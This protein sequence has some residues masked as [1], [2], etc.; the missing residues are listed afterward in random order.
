MNTYLNEALIMKE[1]LLALLLLVGMTACPA[2]VRSAQS[3]NLPS[4]NLKMHFDFSNVSGTSVKDDVSG[5]TASLKGV[6]KV[7]EMG[8]Y[9]VLELGNA[10][11]YMDMTRDA[12]AIVKELLDFTVS[13]CYRVDASASLS[14]QGF[15]LWCFSQSAANTADASPYTAYRLNAQRM[16]TSTGGYN[17]ETG[18]EIGSAS[19]KGRWVHVL[20]R[21]KGQ[22]GELFIDGKRV[23]TNTQMPVLS[24]TFTAVPSYNWIGRPPF[25][26]DNYLKQTQVADFRIYDACVSDDA[27]S[28]LAAEA[29]LL[30]EEYKYG[31]P[32]DFTSLEAKVEECLAFTASAGEKYAPNAVAELKDEI[33]ICQMELKA[34]RASQT[35][36]NEYVTTLTQLL[37]QAKSTVNYTAKKVFEA[38]ADHGFVHPGGIVS[39][40]DIDRAKQLLASGDT[41]IKRAWEIL[42]ANEYSSSGIAT[43]PTETVVRGGSG[44]QNYMNCARGAAMAF[45]N[46]LRWKI[47]GTRANADAA[48]R[49]MMQWARECKGLG[50]DT[51]VSLA[52]GIYGHEWA[53]AAEL[54]RDYDGWSMEDFEEF[55]QW[56]VRVFYNPAIDFLRRRHDTW[57]NARYSNLGQRPGHY[58]SNWGLCNALC[59]MSIGIL[60]DD[61]HM[62]N[63][64]VSFYKYDHVG[65][66]KDRSNLSVILNDGCNEFIGNLVPVVLPDERGPF[67]YLGQMQESG[68]D[69]GHALMALGLAVDIC[70]VGLNQGDDL[71][72]YMDDRIA[73]GAEF[74]AASNFGGMDAGSLPWKNYN[75]ADCRGTMGA[76]WL[77]TGVNTGGSGEYRPYWDRLIG[78][79]EGLRGVKMQY[80][81]AASAKVC[82]DGGGGNYSQNSGGFDHLGFSTLTSWRPAVS[83]EEGITPLSGNIVY[84]GVTYKNQT[85]LG[86]LKYNY[87]VCPSKGIP[88]DG[89]EITLQPQLPEGVT[90]TGQWL[91]NTGETSREITVKADHSYVYRVSFTA[92]NGTMSQQAF[93]IAVCGDAPADVMTNEITVDG[94]IERSTEKTV[95][96]GTSVILYAGST[97]GWTND[98]LWD[99][100]QKNSVITIPAITSSRTYNCQYA[101]Q[102]GAVSESVFQ[103][104]VVPA[105]QTIN[106]TEGSEVEVLSGSSVTLRLVIP[107]YMA[108]A[109]IEW[110]DGSKGDMLTLDNVQDE[111]QVT[112][113]YQGVGYSYKIH[114]KTSDY[115][116]YNLLTTYKGYKLVTSTDELEQLSESHYFILASDDADLLIGLANAPLNG[117]KALFYKTPIDPL[118]DLSKVFTFE[119][120]DG[121]FCLRNI[122]YDG[123]LLQTE[124]NAPHNLR[125]HDQP[126]PI[127][128]ARLLMSYDGAAWTV[129][130][131]TYTGNW[132]GL[133]TPSHGYKDGE[134]IAC[135]KKGDDIGHL[136]IFAISKTRFH[137]EYLSK[138]SEDT[139]LDAT[140]FVVNPQ[141]TG[142]GFG[143]NMSGTWGN[144]RFN[145]A[146]EVWHSTNFNF[147]QTIEGLPNGRYRATCQMANGE[148]GNTGYFYASSGT[149]MEKVVVTQ[150]CKGS[151]FDAERNKMSANASYGLLSLLVTVADGSLT[152]GIK[153]PT[154]GTTWLV[155]D[156]V[157]LT[158]QGDIQS[159]IEDL[160]DEALDFRR[161]SNH[162][163]TIYDLQGRR[164]N[165]VPTKGIYIRNGKKYIVR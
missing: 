30:E 96:E 19:P 131:G 145:G 135:N 141:F 91:W 163:N 116:Y 154:S 15:F 21:Q 115:S 46:A 108:G 159:S 117:N 160:Q 132:L 133:W 97:T 37:A 8:R 94:I 33:H 17:H 16:A 103:L 2:D 112:A 5:V 49:I 143:W 47:G 139:P 24:T 43:W 38:T 63:Q 53:N 48:V 45:Q 86:G 60:C 126:Y 101:N 6:A 150:S 44:G 25:S 121:G 51:N 127:S 105:M 164:L 88:A 157:T 107:S 18:M 50:G 34:R 69:Q 114:V 98:Y 137:Q 7:M 35:L 152:L 54:M 1:K 124:M 36:I 153:E 106:D 41:R 67:G 32:G 118:S 52:A 156:N 27:V 31:T 92:A 89:C 66:Y 122:D 28:K 42:C 148:G 83:A 102:S 39:Q 10:T 109:D 149:E 3:D 134:E 151:N 58:W 22:R 79:Y 4:E 161:T 165:G 144:Q 77:M 128:W 12:G 11:G 65:T 68:R 76:G 82:P 73:A 125:T 9:H 72:A 158:Y 78:Y 130:N 99:N 136:Q 111:T 55:K 146:V 14:G 70:Q 100:G 162:P 119:P 74:V 104:N 140:P 87:N 142:N 85:N 147:S 62:Y 95:L 26:G 93:A 71:F 80:S 56:I 13:V 110:S 75:Y 81:E 120:F 84:K 59:V 20:Y 64:G 123:L 23:Q 61:V 57:L 29:L 138:A 129:E 113:T 90:D 155:W 40:Q